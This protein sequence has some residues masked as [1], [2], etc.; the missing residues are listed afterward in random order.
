MRI[1]PR[2]RRDGLPAVSYLDAQVTAGRPPSK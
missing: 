2:L 1:F